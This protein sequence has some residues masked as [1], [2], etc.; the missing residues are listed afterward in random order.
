MTAAW[1]RQLPVT[2]R[3]LR[4]SSPDAFREGA[5][6]AAQTHPPPRGRCVAGPWALPGPPSRAAASGGTSQQLRSRE[7]T[8]EGRGRGTR[9]CPRAPLRWPPAPPVR[10]L[11]GRGGRGQPVP[12][13]AARSRP[14]VRTLTERSSRSSARR[15]S[16]HRPP[17]RTQR[18]RGARRRRTPHLPS[19]QLRDTLPQQREVAIPVSVLRTLRRPLSYAFKS[20]FS[21]GSLRF[22]RAW[23]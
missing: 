1:Q 16:A 6:G 17:D 7:Q 3:P 11:A 13:G 14:G 20:S 2:S 15:K 4:D 18:G 12:S 22:F 21:F 5:V 8:G 23:M 10:L 19:S 9:G